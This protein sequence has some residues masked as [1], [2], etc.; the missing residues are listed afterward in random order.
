[1]EFDAG[2]STDNVILGVGCHPGD[3]RAIARFDGSAFAKRMETAA[4]VG[5]VGLDGGSR[6]DIAD[7]ERVFGHILDLTRTMPRPLSIH[8]VRAHARTLEMIGSAGARGAILHWW[9]GSAMQTDRAAVLGCWFSVGPGMLR[10]ADQIRKLPRDR[11]LTETDAPVRG[12]VAGRVD[13]VEGVLAKLWDRDIEEVR[14][15]IWRNFAALVAV[16]GTEALLPIP[17]QSF[18]GRLGKA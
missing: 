15:Q 4:F 6:T 1:M 18:V 9:T 14:L 8:S 13:D 17:I 11:V 7:Q 10:A 5:E 3:L 2:R 12:A 16:T